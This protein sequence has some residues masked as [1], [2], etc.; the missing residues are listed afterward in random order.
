MHGP[1]HAEFRQVH[2][3]RQTWAAHECLSFASIRSPNVLR[4]SAGEQQ[5]ATGRGGTVH[6][7]EGKLRLLR[8][9]AVGKAAY[10]DWSTEH[11]HTHVFKKT[12][13]ESRP[14][15]SYLC[16][17]YALKFHYDQN[18]IQNCL[19]FCTATFWVHCGN[20]PSPQRPSCYDPQMC[21]SR[22]SELLPAFLRHPAPGYIHMIIS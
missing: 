17:S 4:P 13:A 10:T 21:L 14:G 12:A 11:I 3:D 8:P 22:I 15:L 2:S 1:Y 5:G 18:L 7:R 16:V 9:Q 20:F 6:S 19:T